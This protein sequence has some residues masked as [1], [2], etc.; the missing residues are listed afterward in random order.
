M[1]QHNHKLRRDDQTYRQLAVVGAAAAAA[2]VVE[3]CLGLVVA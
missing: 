2:A 3:V 1:C